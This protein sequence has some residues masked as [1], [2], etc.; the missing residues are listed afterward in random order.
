MS[1]Q[2]RRAARGRPWWQRLSAPAR[3]PA[4]VAVALAAAIPVLAACC[5]EPARTPKAAGATWFIDLIDEKAAVLIDPEGATHAVPARA[6]PP[7][8]REGMIFAAPGT[9]SGLLPD[10]SLVQCTVDA[11]AARDQRA[12]LAERQSALMRG[13]SGGPIRL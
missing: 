12:R 13:D 4:A 7:G 6:L 3:L 2:H 1:S 9:P 11:R 10:C 5:S 8:A